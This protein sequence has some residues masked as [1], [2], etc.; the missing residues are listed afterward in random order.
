[1]TIA[2]AYA[3]YSSDAQRDESIEIQMREIDALIDRSGWTKGPEYVDRAMTGRHD[4]RPAFRRCLADGEARRFDILV[5]YKT[6]RIARNIG[7]SQ[8]AKRRLFTAG[9]RIVSVREGELRDTPDGFLQAAMQ[10]IMNEYYS[11]DL[12]VKVRAGMWDSAMKCRACGNKRFGYD[13]DA[14]DHYVINDAQAAYVREMF[15]MYIDGRTMNEIRDHLNREGVLT[16][17]GKQWSTQTVAQLMGNPAYKGLYRFMGREVPGGMP[18]IVPPETFDLVQNMRERRKHSKRRKIVNDYML[19]DKAY[20]LDCGQPMC[21]T[22]GTSGTGKK[23]TYYGCVLKDGCGLRVS[24]DLVEEKVMDAVCAMLDDG[25]TVERI[26]EGLT[27]VGEE[28]VTHAEEWE[29]EIAECERRRE[30]YLDAIGDGLPASSV[31]DRLASCEA[32][33]ESLRELIERERATLALAP[34]EETVRAFVAK[35]TEQAHSKNPMA[36]LLASSF[37]DKVF[38]SKERLVIA[39]RLTKEPGEFTFEQVKHMEKCE[40]A[41]KLPVR[42]FGVWWAALDPLRTSPTRTILLQVAV[43]Q[44]LHPLAVGIRQQGHNPVAVLSGDLQDGDLPARDAG[45]V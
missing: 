39:L 14:D 34:D 25:P 13:I 43:D 42:T 5:V 21:G 31:A 7:V 17:R 26:I 30:R 35:A 18:A 20:C 32:R 12:S 8:D 23:Y 44:A 41:G 4:E 33:I 37:V 3:R 19:T 11:R 15:Q 40:P 29:A 45:R 27:E 28:T 6:D 10:D 16:I 2:A 9:V 38:I 1:M 22:A 24:S 36:R